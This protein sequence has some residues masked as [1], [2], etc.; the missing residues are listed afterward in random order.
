MLQINRKDQALGPPPTFFFI[1]P[2]PALKLVTNKWMFEWM[3]EPMDK[4]MNKQI[5]EPIDQW[6][7]EQ[8]KWQRQKGLQNKVSSIF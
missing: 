1:K 3:V 4:Q 6:T 5:D 2:I 7:E 8:T